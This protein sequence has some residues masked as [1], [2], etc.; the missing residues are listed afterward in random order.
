MPITSVTDLEVK[1][2]KHPSHRYRTSPSY[3]RAA[4]PKTF[5][6]IVFQPLFCS[7]G[8]KL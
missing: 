7:L 5:K 3:D 2:I 8:C 4:L 1:K 6:F